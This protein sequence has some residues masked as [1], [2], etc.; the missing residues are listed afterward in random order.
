MHSRL[1]LLAVAAALCLCLPRIAP[2]APGVD[3]LAVTDATG[4]TYDVAPGFEYL[5]SYPHSRLVKAANSLKQQ[6]ETY[7]FH[8][9]AKRAADTGE[10]ATLFI[11]AFRKLP[12]GWKAE[13][14]GQMK[15]HFFDFKPERF[16]GLKAFL[17]GKK[18]ACPGPYYGG[19]LVANASD[20]TFVRFYYVVRTADVPKDSDRISHVRAGFAADVKKKDR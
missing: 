9:Y 16:A 6:A 14:P 15:L 5:G 10:L 1:L 3:G 8:V 13:S 18:L 17:D 2:A 19:S 12:P 20:D 11:A 7:V 4:S